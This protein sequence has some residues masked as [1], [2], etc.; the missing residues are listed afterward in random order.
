LPFDHIGAV[1]RGSNSGDWVSTSSLLYLMAAVVVVATLVVALVVKKKSRGSRGTKGSGRKLTWQKKN[2]HSHRQSSADVMESGTS[3]C[4]IDFVAVVSTSTTAAPTT[5]LVG[6]TT[7]PLYI[8]PTPSP[9]HPANNTAVTTSNR[10]GGRA[11]PP[12]FAAVQHNPPP[13]SAS[14][15]A[16][17]STSESTAQGAEHAA[18]DTIGTGTQSPPQPAPFQPLDFVPSS[19]F[20]ATA[21]D[22]IDSFAPSPTLAAA[23]QGID[24]N[25]VHAAQAEARLTKHQA[26]ANPYQ[27]L[28]TWPIRPIGTAAAEAAVAAAAAAATAAAAAAAAITLHDGSIPLSPVQEA[29]SADEATAPSSSPTLVTRSLLSKT[30]VT[31]VN[32]PYQTT[33]SSTPPAKRESKRRFFPSTASI[34]AATPAWARGNMFSVLD[35]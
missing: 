6:W 11:P 25:S 24:W 7:Q 14:P 15:P 3:D 35:S 30:Q 20:A 26:I 27:P 17:T 16:H 28:F 23:A 10:L 31:V 8:A 33:A 2:H 29:T 18:G 19:P 32:S 1:A 21:D 4:E 13:R 9:P 34:A 22:V 5:A 12:L